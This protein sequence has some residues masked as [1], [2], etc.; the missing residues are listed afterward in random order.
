MTKQDARQVW[1][2]AWKRIIISQVAPTLLLIT[3]VALLQF[4]LASAALPVRVAAL[5]ILLASGI[6][7]ALVQFVS[8]EDASTAGKAL[9][10]GTAVRLLAVIKFVTPAIFL[11]IFAE[12]ALALLA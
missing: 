3:T 11:V 12:L 6:M 10:L 7:G 8:A 2:S 1:D 9:T 4:G 5:L